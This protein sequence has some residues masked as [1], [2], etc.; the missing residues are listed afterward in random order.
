M[1]TSPDFFFD[2]VSQIQIN[3]WS[4]SRVSLVGDACD[5]PSFLAGQGSTLAMVGAYILA[6][7]L[8]EA[9]GNYT[10]AFEAYENIFKPFMES[11]QQSAQKFA[12]SIVPQNK[13][14]IWL[15]NAFTKLK[16]GRASCRERVC[17]YV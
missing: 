17:Q 14:R 16:I 4:Q 6:G 15:R 1:D 2:V 7:E 3:R 11:K 9:N 10:T 8:K 12:A 5:C 13:F